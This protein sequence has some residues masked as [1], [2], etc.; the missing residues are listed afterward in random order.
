MDAM[1]QIAGGPLFGVIAKVVSVRVAVLTAGLLLSPALLL[2]AR[3]V[4]RDKV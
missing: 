1:G 3:T 2:F 4:R